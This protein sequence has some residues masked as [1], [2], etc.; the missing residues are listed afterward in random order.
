MSYKLSRIRV[1]VID[2]NQPI[3][4]LIRSL[5]LD[6]GVGVVDM[7]DTGERGWIEYTRHKHDIIFVDWK[8]DNMAGIEFTKRVRQDPESPVPTVPIIL[9]TGFTNKERVFQARDVGVTE[10]LIKPFTVQGLSRHLTHVI[11]NPRQFVVSPEFVGPDRRRRHDAAE[12]HRKRRKADQE[13]KK[14]GFGMSRIRKRG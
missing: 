13:K 6:L 11:E 10:F 14:K 9:T 7:A 1:L 8:M 3:R 5:L 12:A 2:D 4:M